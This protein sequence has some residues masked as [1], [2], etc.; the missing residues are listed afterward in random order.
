MLL[1]ACRWGWALNDSM[2]R[3]QAWARFAATC[4]RMGVRNFKETEGYGLAQPRA[5][6]PR[7]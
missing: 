4:A 2:A 7:N 3:G 1:I 6:P 5:A